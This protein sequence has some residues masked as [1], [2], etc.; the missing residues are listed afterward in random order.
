MLTVYSQYSK[1]NDPDWEQK[2]RK[3]QRALWRG[4]DKPK[5]VPQIQERI[6]LPVDITYTKLWDVLRRMSMQVTTMTMDDW[7]DATRISGTFELATLQVA[8]EQPEDMIVAS[9]IE[10]VPMDSKIIVELQG[11]IFTGG[12]FSP[13]STLKDIVKIANQVI[14]DTKQELA[15]QTYFGFRLQADG[16]L[17]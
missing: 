9:T 12:Q 16:S 13:Y 14:A 5:P 11:K 4:E 10:I 6:A 3:K 8:V 7:S 17:K 2:A 15:N 1:F